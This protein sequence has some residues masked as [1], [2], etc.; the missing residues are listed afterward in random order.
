[1]SSQQ[2]GRPIGLPM[3]GLNIVRENWGWFVAEGIA[4]IVLG[5]LALGATLWV[6]IAA[7]LFFGSLLLIGGILEAGHAFW[8][9]GWSGFFVDL[10][11][12]LLYAV[13][14][15]LILTHPISAVVAVTLLIAVGLIVGGTFRAAIALS[16]HYQHWIWLL[17]SGLISVLLGVM[18]L[19]QWPPDSLWVIGLFIGI[20]MIFN[21][22]SL[23][24][25]GLAGSALP[26]ET[27]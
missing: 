4:L 2:P 22:W 12:G 10:F 24:M 19:N 7:M 9:R 5:M 16:V 25:L 11:G 20:D 15:L 27:I 21:G 14:G 23:V 8:R 1:M 17:L 18:I 13:L 26:A 3:I 6:G